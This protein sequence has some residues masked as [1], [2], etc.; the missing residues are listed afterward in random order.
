MGEAHVPMALAGVCTVG[1]LMGYMK[2]RSMI[3][4]V[5]GAGVGALYAAAGYM[6]QNGDAEKV[7]ARR[8]APRLAERWL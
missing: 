2:S 6:I 1:G 8:A 7:R 3:S 4:L 5:A